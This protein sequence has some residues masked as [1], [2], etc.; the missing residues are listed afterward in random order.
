MQAADAS[1]EQ[2]LLQRLIADTFIRS[3]AAAALA[4]L[5]E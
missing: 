1:A 5:T 2:Q 4:A 3:P